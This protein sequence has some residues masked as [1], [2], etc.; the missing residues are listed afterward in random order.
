[1][2]KYIRIW[3][4][5]IFSKYVTVRLQLCEGGQYPVDKCFLFFIDFMSDNTKKKCNSYK[6]KC[7]PRVRKYLIL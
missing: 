3:Y 5:Y 4:I 1:M 6:N 2:S 7:H